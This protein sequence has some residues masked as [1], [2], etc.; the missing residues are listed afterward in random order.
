MLIKRTLFYSPA[1]RIKFSF[2]RRKS[3]FCQLAENTDFNILTSCPKNSNLIIYRLAP[4]AQVSAMS[5]GCEEVENMTTGVSLNF[6]LLRISRRQIFP[7]LRGILISRKMISGGG[8]SVAE[9]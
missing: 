5:L 1:F 7:F 4:S 8:F 9:K 3:S 2:E 6:S